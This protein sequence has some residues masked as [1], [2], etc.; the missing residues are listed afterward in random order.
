M[1]LS[2]VMETSE[3]ERRG[4]KNERQ[5]RREKGQRYHKKD[6]PWQHGRS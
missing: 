2:T 3:V 5:K 6:V 1:G 4:A